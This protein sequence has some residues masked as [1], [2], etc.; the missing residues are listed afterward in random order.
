MSQRGLRVLSLGYPSCQTNSIGSGSGQGEQ[1]LR[2]QLPTARGRSGTPRLDRREREA[3]CVVLSFEAISNTYL[4]VERD[5]PHGMLL[6]GIDTN[7]ILPRRALLLHPSV[8]R[9]AEEVGLC[10]SSMSHALARLRVHFDDPLRVSAGRPWRARC[11][12]AR[13]SPRSTRS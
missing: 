1:G 2:E 6:H 4:R 10:Q 13:R 3:R 5:E 9:A 12:R 8:R 11:S 7:L